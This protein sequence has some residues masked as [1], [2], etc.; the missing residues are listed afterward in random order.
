MKTYFLIA[1]TLLFLLGV[2][3]VFFPEALLASWD[4]KSDAAG[5][6]VTR[7]YGGMFFGYATILWLSRRSG[8]SPAVRNILFMGLIVATTMTVLSLYGILTGVAGP[9]MWG[10]V[11]IE[12]ALAVTYGYYYRATR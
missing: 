10:P 12:A 5:Q 7:R 8:P 3:A 1:S 4:M 9:A 2:T 11:V 6:Y